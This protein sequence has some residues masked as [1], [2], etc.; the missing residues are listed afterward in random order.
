[1][2]LFIASHIRDISVWDEE[3]NDA[4]KI[5]AK[6]Y[7]AYPNILLA[8]KKTFEAI[9]KIARKENV[10]DSHGNHPKQPV[11]LSSFATGQYTL[12]FCVDSRYVNQTYAI[13]YDRVGKFEG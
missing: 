2:P 5:F 13:V 11:P 3:I 7:N 9:D 8:S 6:A 10:K 12:S 4:V 1:M